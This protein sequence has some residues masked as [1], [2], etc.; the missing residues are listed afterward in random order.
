MLSNSTG[1]TYQIK[2]GGDGKIYC[3]CLGW[4]FSKETPKS[5]KHLKKYFLDVTDHPVPVSTW[6]P[7][8]S[9]PIPAASTVAATLAALM[10]VKTV[11]QTPT[12]LDHAIGL[13]RK[14]VTAA[15]LTLAPAVVQMMAVELAKHLPA[16]APTVALPSTPIVPGKIRMISFDE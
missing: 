2:R 1:E 16:P 15:R 12:A 8:P 7:V 11:A 6:S 14:M 9:A 5:C 3:S 4:R 13:T 10:P